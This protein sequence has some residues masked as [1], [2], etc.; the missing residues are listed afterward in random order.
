MRGVVTTDRLSL[1][2]KSRK[3]SHIEDTPRS[4]LE[5]LKGLKEEAAE[6][7]G[8]GGGGG[9]EIEEEEEAAKVREEEKVEEGIG[10]R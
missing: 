5:F 9:G 10:I 3:C 2:R 4:L 1:F 6:E 7:G 8:G